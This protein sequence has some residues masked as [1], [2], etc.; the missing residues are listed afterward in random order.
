[1]H[2][3]RDL[4]RGPRDV[5]AG[6]GKYLGA[7]A[8]TLADQRQQEMLGL[9]EGVA[10]LR[11]FARRQLEQLL[12]PGRER[13]VPARRAR[14]V[15][16]ADD[17]L[18]LGPSGAELHPEGVQDLARNPRLL[19]DEAEQEVLGADVV[20]AEQ[21]GFFLRQHDDPAGAG[22]VTLEHRRVPQCRRA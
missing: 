9:D 17:P 22:S 16:A 13:Y 8:A 4:L 7:D 12:G 3:L 18:D 20:V 15:A 1:V 11:R 14:R 10:E 21:P 6:G 19:G 5:D 2:Q